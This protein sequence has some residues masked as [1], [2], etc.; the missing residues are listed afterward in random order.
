M[1]ASSSTLTVTGIDATYYLVKD[2]AR[3]TAFYRDILSLTPTLEIPNVATEF[4]FGSG[5]TF[6]LYE[7]RNAGAWQSSGGV[8]FAVPDVE[9]AVAHCKARGVRFDNDGLIEDTPVCRMA[10]A[11]G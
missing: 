1:S 11:K 7:P 8:M 9:A 6:G 4:T 5:E 2:L 10:F 3:A